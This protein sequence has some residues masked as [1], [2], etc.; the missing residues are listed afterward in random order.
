[1]QFPTKKGYNILSHEF[2]FKEPEASQQDLC[3]VVPK[4][5]GFTVAMEPLHGQVCIIM[6]TNSAIIII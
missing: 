2:H 1:M 6:Y 3:V 5:E 4:P